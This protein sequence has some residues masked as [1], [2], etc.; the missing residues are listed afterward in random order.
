MPEIRHIGVRGDI[1]LWQKFKE[2]AA[3][4]N[5]TA[6]DAFHEAIIDWINMAV[7]SHTNKVKAR[8]AVN[9]LTRRIEEKKEAQ[10]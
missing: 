1:E 6:Q 10:P 5:M 9:E 2:A 3:L 4:M 8:L 7:T